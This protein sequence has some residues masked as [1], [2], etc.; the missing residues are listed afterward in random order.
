MTN[1]AAEAVQNA[2][3]SEKYLSDV[4]LF[5]SKSAD[6]AKADAKAQGYEVYEKN[7][8]NDGDKLSTVVLLGYKTTENKDEAITDLSVLDMK[9]SGYTIVD[10]GQEE[11]KLLPQFS[12]QAKYYLQQA[13]AFRELNKKKTV[14]SYYAKEILNYFYIEQNNKRVAFS[15][16][17]LSDSCDLTF[18]ERMLAKMNAKFIP[19]ISSALTIGS[20][21]PETD[22]WVNL[23]YTKSHSGGTPI[24]VDE[25]GNMFKSSTDSSLAPAGYRPVSRM[26]LR[27]AEN[28][29]T[30]ARAGEKAKDFFL[31]V[32]GEP[33]DVNTGETQ[34]GNGTYIHD[35][36]IAY[37]ETKQGAITA[38]E[39]E[40]A[41]YKVIEENLASS[42]FAYLGYTLTGDP[43]MALRKSAI[44]RCFTKRNSIYPA[45]MSAWGTPIPRRSRMFT[46][47]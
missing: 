30:G 14:G 9:L 24:K 28:L 18:F 39:K 16:Y 15:D 31:F 43:H 32:T 35:I 29:N 47:K 10:I 44:P 38:L 21:D 23:Y 8:N 22:L 4:K 17:V 5:V 40:E 27:S 7:L 37:A 3:L 6:G 19:V 41:G 12:E 45:C 34:K 11:E 20:S 25:D 26:G 33:A 2:S 13:L 36:K 46:Q 42:G 1:A